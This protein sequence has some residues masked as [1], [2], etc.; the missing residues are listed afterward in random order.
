MNFKRIVCAS[1]LA[2]TSHQLPAQMK[3]TC[4]D[5]RNRF[6]SLTIDTGLAN[7]FYHI[8]TYGGKQRLNYVTPLRKLFGGKLKYSFD[9]GS[10][11]NVTTLLSMV[12][13]EEEV[14]G[15]TKSYNKHSGSISNDVSDSTDQPKLMSLG[16][17]LERIDT[18]RIVMIN[19]AH[20]RVQPRAF[21]LSLLSGLKA[22]G[23]THLAM[24]TL[25]ASNFNDVTMNTGYY[26]SEPMFAEIVREALR[27]GFTLVPYEDSKAIQHS[28]AEREIAQAENL[29]NALKAAPSNAKFLVIAGYSHIA[30]DIP[31]DFYITMAMQ[32][33][34]ISG[35]NPFTI[36]QTT[37]LK[38]TDDNGLAVM[39]TLSNKASK[40][41]VVLNTDDGIS[42]NGLHYDAYII[43]PKST[44]RNCRP[45]WLTCGGM[46]KELRVKCDNNKAVLIQ[47]YYKNEITSNQSYNLRIPADQTF[48][49]DE[50]RNA[51]LFLIPKN[52]Y[53]ITFR[54]ENNSIIYKKDVK[55]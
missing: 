12:G 48:Y 33:K 11:Q 9:D 25:S 20:D 44:Y 3:Q 31:N 5:L 36:D 13:A 51:C 49:V 46:K 6:S 50:H 35:I 40:T 15:L 18:C 45:T 2:A 22:K 53:V 8:E 52:N 39:K 17:F 19:E 29:T 27:L 14:I 1:I 10:W 54:D 55:F 16:S 24:E 43:H 34:K 38:E 4:Q 21:I 30:E 42:S 23:F 41:E 37:S 47:A 32:V 26:T 7:Q 28:N